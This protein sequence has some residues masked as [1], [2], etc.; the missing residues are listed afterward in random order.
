M[1]TCLP[2]LNRKTN[3]S[4]KW[5]KFKDW[6][7]RWLR[8]RYQVSSILLLLNHN[9]QPEPCVSDNRSRV[10]H[11]I[12]IT[13]YSHFIMSTM[14]SQNHRHL[15]CLLNR[16]FRRRSKKTLKPCV[17]CLCKGNPL[18]TSDSPHKGPV[19]RK[20]LPFDDVIV[21][22]VISSLQLNPLWKSLICIYFTKSSKKD[23]IITQELA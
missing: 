15:D 8:I 5:W 21:E 14:A 18:V 9:S 6:M 23:A 13:H 12:G 19:T 22:A 1:L 10:Y 7:S 2:L 17:T 3:Y 16:L 11:E 4:A 20:M